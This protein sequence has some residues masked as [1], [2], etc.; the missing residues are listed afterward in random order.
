MENKKL[1][2]K[3]WLSHE[4]NLDKSKTYE[5]VKVIPYKEAKDWSDH[6]ILRDEAGAETEV[7][8]FRCIATPLDNS[9]LSDE[10]ARIADY[11]EVNGVNASDVSAGVAFSSHTGEEVNVVLVSIDWGDWSKEHGFCDALMGH[12]GYDCTDENV[13]DENGSDCYSSTH[14]FSK[15]N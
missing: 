14:C 12:I 5:V 2:R 7:Q 11:L 4:G 15:S 8:S 6:L 1:N 13:Y 9:V 10:I 3:V